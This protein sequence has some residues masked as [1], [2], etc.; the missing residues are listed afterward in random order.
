MNIKNFDDKEVKIIYTKVPAQ[1]NA[2][3]LCE[4]PAQYKKPLIIV[5]PTLKPRRPF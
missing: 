2:E 3:G 4:D 1:Y 5:D